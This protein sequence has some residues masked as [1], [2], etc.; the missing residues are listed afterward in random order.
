MLL[1]IESHLWSIS[2]QYGYSWNDEQSF[3]FSLLVNN[4]GK[5]YQIASSLLLTLLGTI[6][7][8]INS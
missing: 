6:V 7:S 4:S 5:C 8:Y 2:C 1:V 3:L